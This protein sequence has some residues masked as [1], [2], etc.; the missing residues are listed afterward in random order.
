MVCVGQEKNRKYSRENI[1]KFADVPAIDLSMFDAMPGLYSQS[2][3]KL[4]NSGWTEGLFGFWFHPNHSGKYALIA[5]IRM[6]EKDDL[7]DAKAKKLK[8]DMEREGRML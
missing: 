8:E 1:M 7:R 4:A 5:A 3:P 2:I 6:M